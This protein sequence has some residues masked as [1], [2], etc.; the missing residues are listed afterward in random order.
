MTMN[1]ILGFVMHNYVQKP[2]PLMKPMTP[3]P[4]PLKPPLLLNLNNKSCA[5]LIYLFIFPVMERQKR[6]DMSPEALNR[7]RQRDHKMRIIRHQNTDARD[8]EN[9]A[10]RKQHGI[11]RR[12]PVI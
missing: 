7:S 12:D 2:T 1:I 11:R 6:S 9:V 4:P 10:N 5:S 3:Q 8:A